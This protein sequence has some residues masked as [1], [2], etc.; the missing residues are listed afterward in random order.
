MRKTTLGLV[1]RSVTLLAVAGLLAAGCADRK[2][3]ETPETHVEG[4]MDPA[5]SQFHGAKIE[6]V[7]LISCQDCHGADYKGGTSGVSCYKCHAGGPSGHP[8]GWMDSTSTH[9]HGLT[10]AADGT[11]GCAVCHGEDF[12]GQEN[13]GSSCYLCHN[14]PSGH[15]ASGWLSKTSANF[16]GLAASIRGLHDC[17][18]CHGA[19]FSGGTSGT[20]CTSCHQ[21]PSGHPSTGWLDQSSDKFHAKR[22]SVT[23]LSYC[24]GCHGA[25]YKGG[26]SGVSCYQCHNGPSGHPSVGWLDKTNASFHGLAAST[27]GLP[28]CATCHGSDF[29]GG[30]SGASCYTCHSTGPSG[31]PAQSDWL[32]SASP[33]FHG[34]RL[35][36]TGTQYCAG[37]HGSDF[38]GGYAQVSCYTCHD[39]PSGHPARWLDKTAGQD[40]H[41]TV[42]QKS[43]VTS[44]LPC[45]GQDLSG[46][47]SGVACSQCH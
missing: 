11:A 45:H 18:L 41:G 33:R 19:D 4:W 5:S 12:R 25:D 32:N 31:H 15:P 27:R 1:L 29:K 21:N 37:C 46:G 44:C 35:S 30:T 9:F 10:V 28:D 16:H 13:N 17:A 22:M 43:G 39:G 23:G 7:N 20:S 8:G 36:Q 47:I 38:K 6:A 34:V 14:G 2:E 26:E 40:F 24:A 42:V 3:L